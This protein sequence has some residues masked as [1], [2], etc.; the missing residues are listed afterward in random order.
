M[1]D[2]E[3]ARFNMVE[4][5]VRP[6]G[7]TSDRLLAAMMD[8]PRENFVPESCRLVAYAGSDVPYGVARRTLPEPM[9]FARLVQLAEVRPS[10]SVLMIG[11]GTGYGAAVAARLAAK[12][13]SLE[14]EPALA[15]MAKANLAGTP[16]AT[17]FEGALEEG[18]RNLAPFDVII[19]LG[20]AEALPEQLFS[21]LAEGGKLVVAVGRATVVP[22]RVWTV[23]KGSRSSRQGFDVALPLLPC[24][25]ARVEEFVF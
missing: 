21:Q 24:F 22:V 7:V 2:L 3:L 14:T 15:A 12:V 25:A 8:V 13:V 1:S 19:V 4:S 11:D 6:N 9:S 20:R 18:C 16:N 5:Q 17:A 23:T 10:D